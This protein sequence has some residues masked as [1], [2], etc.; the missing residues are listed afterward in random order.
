MDY[1]SRLRRFLNS[2]Y[3]INC[4]KRDLYNRLSCL[5]YNRSSTLYISWCDF[6]EYEGKRVVNAQKER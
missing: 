3:C 5:A 6:C 1:K 4:G 2:L